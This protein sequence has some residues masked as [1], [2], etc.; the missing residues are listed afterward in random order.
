MEE[1]A[2]DRH[3]YL[4]AVYEGGPPVP[5]WLLSDG[6]LRF[7]HHDTPHTYAFPDGVQMRAVFVE[8]AHGKGVVVLRSNP[9]S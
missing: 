9:Q 3:L 7:L 6:T 4:S 8:H 5:S 1:Q 2:H